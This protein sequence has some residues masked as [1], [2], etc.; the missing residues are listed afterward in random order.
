MII[1]SQDKD[2]I[3]NFK[4][5]DAIGIG[6]PLDN[7][8]GM[9]KILASTTSDNEYILGKYSTKERAKEVLQEI[10]KVY[11]FYNGKTYYVEDV[12]NLLGDYEKGVYVMPVEKV[13]D[14]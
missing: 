5:T 3:L 4:N 11:K 14:K 1:V 7:D 8:N 9:F 2:L 10:I 6:K 12:H 13:D